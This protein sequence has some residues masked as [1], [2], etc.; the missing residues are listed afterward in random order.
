M[1]GI[2]NKS[3][4]FFIPECRLT[5]EKLM[6]MSGIKNKSH[7]FFIPECRLTYEKLM[8]MSGIKKQISFVFYFRMQ[9]HLSFF[10]ST[11][12]LINRYKYV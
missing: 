12:R 11:L 2:K 10:V 4:L 3:H 7:L 6:Q 9:Q 8:Q 1:S 5:Y